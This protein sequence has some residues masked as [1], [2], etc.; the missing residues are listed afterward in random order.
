MAIALLLCPQLS[1]QTTVAITDGGFNHTTGMGAASAFVS[2]MID[3]NCVCRWSA[4]VVGD[5]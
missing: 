2:G 3:E 4:R 5:V 1:G